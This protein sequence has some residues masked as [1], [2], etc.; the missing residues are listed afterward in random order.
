MEKKSILLIKPR[1]NSFTRTKKTRKRLFSSKKLDIFEEKE[2]IELDN[3]LA[4]YK[5]NAHIYTQEILQVFKK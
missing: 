2:I 5:K 3:L 1:S 4:H